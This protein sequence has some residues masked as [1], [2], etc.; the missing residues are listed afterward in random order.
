TSFLAVVAGRSPGLHKFFGSRGGPFARS[1]Q[2]FWQSW[3]AVRQ[4]FTS[5]LAVVAGRLP[6][7]SKFF[8]S[9]GLRATPQGS[10]PWTPLQEV[11]HA[12]NSRVFSDVRPDAGRVPIAE[13]PSRRFPSR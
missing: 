2:V 4:V 6:G 7:L 13:L 10:A 5:F 11:P 9:R 3:R 8:C 1:S 12:P